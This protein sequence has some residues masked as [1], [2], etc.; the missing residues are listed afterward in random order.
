MVLD[1]FAEGRHLV[2]DAVVNTIYKKHHHL[3]GGAYT[4]LCNKA[5]RRLQS[6][7][8]PEFRSS[9]RQCSWWSPCPG[10]LPS[11]SRMVFA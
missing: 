2:I 6:P 11:P 3:E 8:G 10:P 9:N 1:L 4:W 7:R 5:S